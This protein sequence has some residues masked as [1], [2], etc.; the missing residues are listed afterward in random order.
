MTKARIQIKTKISNG[1]EL[2]ADISDGIAIFTCT[3]NYLLKQLYDLE[4]KQEKNKRINTTLT[5]W[6][7]T[8]VTAVT[9]LYIGMTKEEIA[10]ELRKELNG[11]K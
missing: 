1:A 6:V 2:T 10:I 9:K 11:G 4:K 8:P 7:D 5:K 3:D